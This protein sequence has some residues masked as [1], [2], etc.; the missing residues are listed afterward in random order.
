MTSTWPA[1]QEEFDEVFLQDDFFSE[2]ISYTASGEAAKTIKAIVYR[3]NAVSSS[4][5]NDGLADNSKLIYDVMIAISRDADDGIEDVTTR[6]D[7]A[8]FP[9]D[10]GDA[11]QSWRVT[12]IVRQDP[13]VWY[14]GLSK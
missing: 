13:A 5:R 14:L 4:N 7:T 1:L 9:L 11:N 3:K 2:D 10:L 12:Q 8:S 6:E